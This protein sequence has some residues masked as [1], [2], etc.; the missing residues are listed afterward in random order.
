MTMTSPC[1][2]ALLA[3]QFATIPSPS[4][5]EEGDGNP[6]GKKSYGG[7]GYLIQ[8]ALPDNSRTITG[9]EIHGSR[10]GTPAEKFLIY[11]LS[12]DRSKVTAVEMAPYSLF[13]RGDERWVVIPFEK[14]LDIPEGG[15]IAIDFRAGR[16][17]GVYVSY[18]A[19]PGEKRSKVGL[20]GLDAKEVDFEGDW[21][22]RPTSAK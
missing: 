7:S 5:A 19:H 4:F 2:F 13:E 8:P 21:M 18:D 9:L 14:P 17:K 3:I 22:I 20:P 12:A 16:T 11:I 6:D 1:I 10:Y 15:W